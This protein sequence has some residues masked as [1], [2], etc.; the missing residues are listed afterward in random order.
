MSLTPCNTKRPLSMLKFLSHNFTAC[1]GVT[2]CLEESLLSTYFV[3]T[4]HHL[5]GR[6]DSTS[7]KIKEEREQADHQI[8]WWNLCRGLGPWRNGECQTPFG[9]GTLGWGEAETKARE[10]RITCY[11]INQHVII[12]SKWYIIHIKLDNSFYNR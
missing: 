10:E 9:R 1:F 6:R 5:R 8:L 4:K 12:K 7:N 3:Y 11:R 2:T